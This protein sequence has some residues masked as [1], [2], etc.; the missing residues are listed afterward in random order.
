MTNT[1]AEIEKLENLK[2][3]YLSG[4]VWEAVSLSESSIPML[5][6]ESGLTCFFLE[7]KFNQYCLPAPFST[8]YTSDTFRKIMFAENQE[9]VDILTEIAIEKE[10]QEKQEAKEESIRMRKDMEKRNK[11][12]YEALS[13]EEKEKED[14]EEKRQIEKEKAG[15]KK[16]TK[17]IDGK[18]CG[19]EY[20]SEK[21]DMCYACACRKK[22]YILN[23]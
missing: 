18:E 20:D 1:N 9:Q 15:I 12:R 14:K 16:C 13:D 21:Y 5:E 2:K 23:K 11:E 19:N 10:K 22:G 6:E 3:I 4:V 7:K 8:K 17:V